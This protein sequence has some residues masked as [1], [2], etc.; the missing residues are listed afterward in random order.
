MAAYLSS[1]EYDSVSRSEGLCELN[2]NSAFQSWFDDRMQSAFR[3]YDLLSNII[4]VYEV[5]NRDP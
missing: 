3:L 5:T 4:D 1:K 2:A